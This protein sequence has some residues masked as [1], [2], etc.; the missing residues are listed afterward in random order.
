MSGFRFVRSF[1]DFAVGDRRRRFICYRAWRSSSRGAWGPS[2]L[3][4]RGW[5]R[6]YLVIAMAPF[7][8]NLSYASESEAARFSPQELAITRNEL[9]R[10]L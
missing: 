10:L 3:N 9:Q 5:L 8:Q 1:L 2:D 6:N 7:A 4:P